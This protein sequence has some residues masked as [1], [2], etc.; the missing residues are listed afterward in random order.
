[1]EYFGLPASR[2]GSADTSR[3]DSSGLLETEC[4]GALPHLQ[5]SCDSPAA[6]LEG[7]AQFYFLPAGSKLN[8]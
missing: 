5:P 1:M 6:C 4:L 2:G 8:R 7:F 3:S